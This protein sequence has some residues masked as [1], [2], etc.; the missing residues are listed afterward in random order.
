[1]SEF[2]VRWSNGNERRYGT[3]EAAVAGVLDSYPDAEI[4]HDGDISDG[5]DLT[6]VWATEADSEDD[7]GANAIAS[8]RRLRG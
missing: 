3:Y 8:I 1:M 6:L 4:G 5:G 7:D 2:T